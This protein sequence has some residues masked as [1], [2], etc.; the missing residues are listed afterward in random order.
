MDGLEGCVLAPDDDDNS[1]SVP[2]PPA[3]LG[4]GALEEV[5]DM[6]SRLCRLPLGGE[7]HVEDFPSS[8]SSCT[9]SCGRQKKA[10]P[11]SK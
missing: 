8:C 4:N 6:G 11:E 1:L 10:A 2:I 3:P 9:C 5:E 7:S